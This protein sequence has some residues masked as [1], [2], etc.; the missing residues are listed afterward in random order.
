MRSS[1]NN[2]KSEEHVFTVFNRLNLQMYVIKDILEHG[3]FCLIKL[4]VS[5]V[6]FLHRFMSCFDRSSD[7]ITKDW[8]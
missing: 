6:G 3:R 2:V 1:T 7:L 4:F 5:T 8:N